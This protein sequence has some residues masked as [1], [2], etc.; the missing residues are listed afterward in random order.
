[1]NE[2]EMI[3]SLQLQVEELK[4]KLSEVHQ[5]APK[6]EKVGTKNANPNLTL[7]FGHKLSTLFKNRNFDK[8]SKF[9]WKKIKRTKTRFDQKSKF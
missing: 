3:R 9:C 4:A 8:E 7:N 5:A 6:R 2:T 1:M